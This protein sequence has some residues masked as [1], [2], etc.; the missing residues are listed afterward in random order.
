MIIGQGIVV[1]SVLVYLGKERVQK[2]DMPGAVVVKCIS[3]VR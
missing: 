1:I 3:F 2:V